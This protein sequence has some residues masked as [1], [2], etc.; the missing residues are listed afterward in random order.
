MDKGDLKTMLSRLGAGGAVVLALIGGMIEITDVS[1]LRDELDVRP[2]KSAGYV[3]DR[4]A[5]INAQGEIESALG[6]AADCVRVDG[7]S[8]PCDPGFADAEV[9][10]GL[11]DGENRVFELAHEPFPPASLRFYRNGLLLTEGKY[12]TVYGTFV[13][14]TRPPKPGD[15]LRADYRY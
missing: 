12:Y 11:V 7:T 5:I 1:G 9:P 4:V 13:T 15:R 3:P 8:Q 10:V 14:L 2:M 6:D